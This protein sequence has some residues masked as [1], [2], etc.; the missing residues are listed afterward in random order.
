VLR[1]AGAVEQGSAHLLART[2]VEAAHKALTNVGGVLPRP[3][4]VR[5]SPGRGVTGFVEGHEVAVGARTFIAERHPGAVD[6]MAALETHFADDAGLRAFVWIDEEV[7][8]VVEYA[9][10]LRDDAH[11]VLQDFIALGIRR[12]VLLSG[13]HEV[14]VRQIANTLG[15]ADA[16]ADLRPQDKAAIIRELEAEGERVLMIGD[17]INDAP[18]MSVATVGVSLAAHGGGITAEAAGI[19]VLTDELSPIPEAIRISRRTMAIVRR[20][21]I[22]GLGLSGVAMVFAAAGM[23][24]AP[25]GALLQE[26]IDVI[27]ILIA[28]QAA[29][30]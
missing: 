25:V 22:V 24:A 10:R 13:D 17:G 23:I 26:V 20:S 3:T 28:L 30:G 11:A 1:L 18:A 16:R 12:I 15:I 5:E 9:D 14:N 27:S 7:A 4:R 19:V 29:R 21:L 6:E 8:G 2:L